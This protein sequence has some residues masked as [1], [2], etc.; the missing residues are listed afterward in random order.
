MKVIVSTMKGKSFK[1]AERK[2]RIVKN[3]TATGLIQVNKSKDSESR[4][5]RIVTSTKTTRE[6]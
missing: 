1:V 6:E 4:G 2:E 5:E 3:K